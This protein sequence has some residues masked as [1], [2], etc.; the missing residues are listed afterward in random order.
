MG[1]VATVREAA[2]NTP[3]RRNRVLDLWRA[4]SILVVVLGHWTM[5]AVTV[6]DGGL[7]PGHLLVLAGWTHPL[8]WAFQVM[9]VFFLVDVYA[10][11]RSWRSA[12]ERATPYGAWLRGRA[13]RLTLPVVPVLL[14]WPAAGWLALQA[15]VDWRTLRLATSVALVPTWFLAAHVLVVAL[16]PATVRLWERWGWWSVVAGGLASVARRL[17]LL[18]GTGLATAVLL[19]QAGPYPVSMVGLDTSAVDNT[20]PT[21]VTLLFLGMAQAGLLLLL[22]PLAR[23]LVQGRRA[24]T[25]V[26]AVNAR[27]MTVYLWHVTAMVL[28]IAASLLVG[29][30]GLRARPLGASWW[31]SRPLWF[32]V[33]AVVTTAFVAGLGR[34]ETVGPDPRPAPPAWRPLLAVAGVCAGLAALA[35]VGAVDS[36]GLSWVLFLVPVLAVVA[37][38]LVRSP[39]LPRDARPDGITR[40]RR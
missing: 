32:L 31:W 40:P 35:V 2:A 4:V 39:G 20:Y 6:R 38:G 21:R 23:R 1:F 10:N 30:V 9:P 14:F 27:I 24:W 11:G 17:L 15:G 37:G 34:L 25:L 3:A 18:A 22:D 8:T 29:G 26:V 12:R 28:V 33:L 7:V 36:D 19:V 16:A 5:A 13:R